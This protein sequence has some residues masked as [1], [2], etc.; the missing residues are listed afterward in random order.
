[1]TMLK[2]ITSTLLGSGLAFGLAVS[3]SA[4]SYGTSVNYPSNITGSHSSNTVFVDTRN[5]TSSRL[6]LNGSSTAN[7]YYRKGIRQFEKGNLKRAEEH[8]NAVLLA[9]G[10]NQQAHYYL[11]KINLKQGD[12]KQAAKHELLM[13]SIKK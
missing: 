11:A 8:F 13:H 2:L 7:K 6:W 9:N 1:M 10:L 12:K 5:T 4:N 3:A